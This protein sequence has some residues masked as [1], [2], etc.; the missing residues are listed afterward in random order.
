MNEQQDILHQMLAKLDSSVPPDQ[1]Y[2]CTRSFLLVVVE[3]VVVVVIVVVVVVVVV[4][5]DAIVVTKSISVPPDC[6][7]HTLTD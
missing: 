4:I 6:S 2:V 5:V 3:A 7:I 1:S